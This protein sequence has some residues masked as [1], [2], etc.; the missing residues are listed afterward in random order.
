ME[1]ARPATVDDVTRLLA[2][3]RDLRAELATVRGGDL[4]HRT[5]DPIEH[6]EAALRGLLDYEDDCVL[7]GSIDGSVVGYVLARAHSLA[8]GSRLAT[9]GDP[10]NHSTSQLVSKLKTH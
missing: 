8:D 7:V 6:S 3:S 9:V 4:W 10:K 2:L 1:R 5:H